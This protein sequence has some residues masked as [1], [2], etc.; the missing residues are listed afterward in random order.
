MNPVQ[1]YADIQGSPKKTG[2]YMKSLWTVAIFCWANILVP[3]E[4]WPEIKAY[5]LPPIPLPRHTNTSPS[6]PTG[7][8]DYQKKER[9]LE[10]QV[11]GV[12]VKS[13]LLSWQEARLH[14]RKE[15]ETLLHTLVVTYIE[16]HWADCPSLPKHLAKGFM[17][18]TLKVRLRLE[19]TDYI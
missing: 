19:A 17:P 2:H 14:I 10:L 6:I 15:A 3:F 16:H 11:N 5:P 1:A 7:K 18:R 9:R 13:R 4:R 12:E 8:A